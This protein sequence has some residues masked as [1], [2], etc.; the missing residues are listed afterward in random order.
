[1]SSLELDQVSLDEAPLELLRHRP[2]EPSEWEEVGRR[3]EFR[4]AL[5]LQAYLESPGSFF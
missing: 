1:M 4:W 5:L 3:V 2:A